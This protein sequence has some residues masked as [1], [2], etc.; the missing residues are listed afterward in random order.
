[1]GITILQGE[2]RLQLIAQIDTLVADERLPGKHGRDQDSLL[3][4]TQLRLMEERPALIEARARRDLIEKRVEGRIA[5]PGEVTRRAGSEG[6]REQ[7]LRVRVGDVSKQNQ[8]ID[9]LDD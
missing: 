8:R 9:V 4:N 7:N 1:M 5:E 3:R 6:A 2:R